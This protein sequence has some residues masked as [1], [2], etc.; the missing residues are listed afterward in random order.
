MNLL[1]ALLA[2]TVASA[3]VLV[4]MAVTMFF[5]GRTTPQTFVGPTGARGVDGLPGLNGVTGA[6]GPTGSSATTGLASTGIFDLEMLN[7]SPGT[8]FGNIPGPPTTTVIVTG[9]GLL[10]STTAQYTVAQ[11]G[12]YT[13]SISTLEVQT[14]PNGTSVTIAIQIN[15]VDVASNTASGGA[16]A[17]VSGIEYSAPLT[18]GDVISFLVSQNGTT[19][20]VQSTTTMFIVTGRV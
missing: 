6:R 15:G 18:S 2:L 1:F 3:V 12:T 8:H 10:N 4:S 7:V 20:T 11:D 5:I 16:T 14:I 17:T 13:A 9:M 19:V